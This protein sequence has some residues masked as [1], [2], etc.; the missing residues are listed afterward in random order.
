MDHEAQTSVRKR[1]ISNLVAGRR[2][3]T[4][5][6]QEAYPERTKPHEPDEPRDA[7]SAT[8]GTSLRIKKSD[9][10]KGKSDPEYSSSL[11]LVLAELVA[12]AQA[13]LQRKA[14]SKEKIAA[15]ATSQEGTL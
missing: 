8:T 14:P 15:P 6:R 10:F 2:I 13:D 4:N 9:E 7:R 5:R 12:L 11:R 1:V 3:G